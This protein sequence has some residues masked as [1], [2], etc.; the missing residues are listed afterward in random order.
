M[1]FCGAKIL[2]RK[3]DFF[4]LLYYSKRLS[5]AYS[6]HFP[7]CQVACTQLLHWVKI[8]KKKKSG[9]YNISDVE[10]SMNLKTNRWNN[11]KMLPQFHDFL[12]NS[13]KT[14]H[15]KITI[16]ILDPI[17]ITFCLLAP[18]MKILYEKINPLFIIFNSTNIIYFHSIFQPWMRYQIIYFCHLPP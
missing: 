4:V 8:L 9:L 17:S 13:R 12:S 18:K 3:Y 11:K 2:Y 16:L 15:F 10:Y 6:K 7:I 5:G 1:S 14:I